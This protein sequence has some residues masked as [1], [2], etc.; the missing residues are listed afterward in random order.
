M[1][2]TIIRGSVTLSSKKCTVTVSS[3]E[4]LNPTEYTLWIDTENNNVLKRW[5]NGRWVIINDKKEVIDY[6][7]EELSN[8]YYDKTTTNDLIKQIV[9][10]VK[11]TTDGKVSSDFKSL[12]TRIE[13]SNSSFEQRSNEIA[14]TVKSLKSTVG[15]EVYTSTPTVPYS[16]KDIWVDTDS[17]NNVTIK[18]C[19]NARTKDEVFHTEDW[20]AI[21][22][23]KL[24]SYGMICT[25]AYS[26]VRQLSDKID[27]LVSVDGKTSEITMTDKFINL[28]SANINFDGVANFT[29]SVKNVVDSNYSL[30]MLDKI[31]GTGTTTIDGDKIHSYAKEENGG[32]IVH[33]YLESG[34]L[35]FESY[36][37]GDR[38]FSFS[39]KS[40]LNMKWMSQKCGIKIEETHIGW[41]SGC[42]SLMASHLFTMGYYKT[43]GEKLA[44]IGLLLGENYIALYNPENTYWKSIYQSNHEEYDY[45]CD[46]IQYG[47]RL[48]Y[49]GDGFFECNLGST[50]GNSLTVSGTTTLGSTLSVSGT[51]TLNSTLT[52]S[53][54]TTLNNSLTVSGETTHTDRITCFGTNKV[55]TNIITNYG[56]TLTNSNYHGNI[57]YTA[58]GITL[59]N[60]SG[61]TVGSFGFYKDHWSSKLQAEYIDA[62]YD[63]L[64][65]RNLTVNGTTTLSST[66]SVSGATTLNSTLTV[67]G[68]T[69]TNNISVSGKIVTEYLNVNKAVN[70]YNNLTVEGTMYIQ[71]TNSGYKNQIGTYAMDFTKSNSNYYQCK[72]RYTA[73]GIYIYNHTGECVGSFANYNDCWSSKLQAE[74]IE[75]K[76]EIRT[77]NVYNSAGLITSSDR[78]VKKDIED[79]DDNF[80]NTLIDSIIPKTYKYTNGT[81]DRTHCGAIAQDVEDVIVGMGLTTKDFGG[82]VKDYKIKEVETESGNVAIEA[83]YETEPDYYLRY[84][85][86]IMPL[87]RY[88]QLLKQRIEVLENTLNKN[89]TSVTDEANI[90]NEINVVSE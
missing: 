2:K 15:G 73:D 81:S 47:E 21:G 19:K 82:V 28:I 32:K 60:V 7:H 17:S 77:Q 68:T 80:V 52:V 42:Y 88:C 66:L 25:S 69:T 70:F 12:T 65:K 24:D 31:T 13:E 16:E 23:E 10:E 78:K 6:I 54:T 44:R 36:G 84:E 39:I 5:E 67:N 3:T 41:S 29:N 89:E 48:F 45:I 53:G 20:Q 18:L 72:V 59:I 49:V 86:F 55:Y 76:Y 4:P 46:N 56:I 63:I 79:I 8:K 90:T 64:C 1:A 35:R 50:F 61:D 71:N 57:K 87:V 85:E 9:G 43:E 30:G 62:K 22:D 34:S 26:R 58:D 38:Q 11:I 40:G 27:L 74:Y 51:T 33:C 83:D 75:G 37:F 14:S